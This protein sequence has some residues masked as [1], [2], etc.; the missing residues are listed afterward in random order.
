M[1]LEF[2][3]PRMGKRADAVLVAKDLIFVI[4]YKVGAK[5]YQRH[6][7]DQVLDYALDLKNFHAGSHGLII[8]PVLVATQA[9]DHPNTVALWDDEVVQPLRANQA[10]L[11]SVINAVLEKLG[12]EPID[13]VTWVAAPY[14]PT[15][16]IVEAAQAL[17]QGH[18]VQ[19]ISRSE[20]GAENLSRTA[21]YISQVIETAKQRGEKAI[22]F[23]TGVP[24]SGK[25]LAGLNIAN[26]RMKAHEDEHAVFLSGNGPLVA[27]LREALAIDEVEQARVKGEKIAK[28]DA[29][30]HAGN[31]VQNIHHFR[32]E[33]VGTAQAPTERVVVFDEA[34]RGPGPRNKPLASCERSE[35]RTHLICPSRSSC[36]R[37]WTA[38]R[39]GVWWCV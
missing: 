20:A 5:E 32:D 22:C 13:P 25:T 8:V 28:K 29:L 31:F 33:Y 7:I 18:D 14:R 16:T 30:R 1:F 27:V 26:E 34:Q 3:I 19:E 37:S 2:A 6:A 11:V 38:I 35:G 24:G 39:V 15:P 9:P 21:A 10:T 12:G 4:E 17:Y 23:V 36:F